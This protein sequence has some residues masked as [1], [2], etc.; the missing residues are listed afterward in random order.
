MN[1]LHYPRVQLLHYGE[2]AAPDGGYLHYLVNLL[3]HPDE[4]DGDIAELPFFTFPGDFYQ[5]G[6]T[7]GRNMIHHRSSFANL[8]LV[9]N[10]LVA[11]PALTLIAGII[12]SLIRTSFRNGLPT[13]IFIAFN[14]QLHTLMLHLEMLH[15]FGRK[16]IS[17]T[18]L[19][20]LR[21]SGS[22]SP[23]DIHGPPRPLT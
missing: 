10:M 4:G 18:D 12:I 23:S 16:V 21:P 19:R 11:G 3:H 2:F 6:L 15:V 8:A 5:P 17:G 14:H 13:R 7:K 20:Q 22:T 9:S 1:L